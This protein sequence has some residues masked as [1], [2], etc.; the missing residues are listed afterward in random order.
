MEADVKTYTCSPCSKSQLSACLQLPAYMHPWGFQLM[1]QV[2]FHPL[3]KPRLSLGSWFWL[4]HASTSAVV[5]IQK[6]SHQV[7]VSVHLSASRVNNINT[8]KQTNKSPWIAWKSGLFPEQS[9]GVGI[10]LVPLSPDSL[11]CW[12]WPLVGNGMDNV[13]R[14]FCSLTC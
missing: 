12:P 5:S 4:G 10:V 1:M 9:L 6:M 7:D 14:R 13:S 11:I 3:G 2:F 8:Y